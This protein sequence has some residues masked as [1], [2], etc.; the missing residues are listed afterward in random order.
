MTKTEPHA[1]IALVGGGLTTQVLAL[2]L[3]H[4]GFDFV[5]FSGPP[6]GRPAGPDTRTTT[7]HH[8]G[9]VMLEALGIWAELP[10]PACPVTEIAVAGDQTTAR[11]R[12]RRTDWP[13][14]WQQDSPP[15]AW[16]VSNQ[17]L[18]TACETLIRTTLA[19]EQIK[20]VRIEQMQG[21]PPNQLRDEQQKLWSC[22]LVIG[23][24]GANSRLR[25][26]AGLRAIDQSRDETAL[27]TTVKTE[28]PVAGTAYQRFLPSG[29]LALMP[30]GAKSASVVWSLPEARAAELKI[31]DRADFAAAITTAFGPELG[32]LTPDTPCLAW[33]LKP[34]YCPRI[35]TAGFVLAGDAAHALHPLA[36]MGFNLA[37]SDCAVLLDC[38]QSAARA[39]LTPG[40]AS[41]TTAYQARRKPEILALTSA[42]QGLNRLLTRPQDPLYQLAC[43]G[44]SVL[45]QIPARRLLSEL[46]MGGRLSSAPLFD[47][48]LHVPAG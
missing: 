41:V 17:A 19:D 33:P 39:G 28:R 1:P 24:D 10:E 11:N 27:V 15:M 23:C 22:D 34:A 47:G 45:G 4:S 37:L 38:L 36:G 48:H 21:G 31:R 46:A 30:T 8:A 14:R 7:I 20:A 13:L 6:A 29:P 9:K 3:V 40:H 5:W 32:R 18:K 16:V 25:K 35:S 2:T 44:M 12:R 42:T 26:Q 43:V